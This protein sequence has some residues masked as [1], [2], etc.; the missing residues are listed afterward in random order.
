VILVSR[1]HQAL[2]IREA[3]DAS[4]KNRKR[5]AES[6]RDF[7]R[8]R[9]VSGG[10]DGVWSHKPDLT[11]AGVPDVSANRRSSGPWMSC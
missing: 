10:M 6:T 5:L 11:K 1:T 2:E 8:R 7:K 9:Y 4:L 3:K